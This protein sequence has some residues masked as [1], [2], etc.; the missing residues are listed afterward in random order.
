MGSFEFQLPVFL[1]YGIILCCYTPW[2]KCIG[3]N[4][5]F[6]S[7]GICNQKIVYDMTISIWRFVYVMNKVEVT[8]I[9]VTVN[10]VGETL[11]GFSDFFG[12]SVSGIDA[13][14]GHDLFD[15]DYALC[16]CVV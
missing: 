3:N 11:F 8:D 6:C 10:E 14:I 16:N 15:R 1:I 12:V 4:D 5:T 13:G 7:V 9:G 2:L